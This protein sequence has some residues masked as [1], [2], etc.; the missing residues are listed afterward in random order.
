MWKNIARTVIENGRVEDNDPET[1]ENEVVFE[2]QE[3]GASP[4][5]AQELGRKAKAWYE[6]AR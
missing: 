5:E 3:Q 6:R 1:L 2:A 4:E